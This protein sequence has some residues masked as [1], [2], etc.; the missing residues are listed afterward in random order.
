MDDQITQVEPMDVSKKNSKIVESL[1]DV[2]TVIMDKEIT[3]Y[4]NDTEF[5]EGSMI[6]DSGMAYN[7]NMG[8][9]IKQDSGC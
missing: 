7:C 2:S 9:W 6:C 3:C 1:A 8:Y 4:W 5:Q